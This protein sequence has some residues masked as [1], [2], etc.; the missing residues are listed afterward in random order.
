M[1]QPLQPNA[2]TTE[3]GTWIVAFDRLTGKSHASGRTLTDERN[4]SDPNAKLTQWLRTKSRDEINRTTLAVFKY[5]RLDEIGVE[6]I[7]DETYT[8]AEWLYQPE[9]PSPRYTAEHYLEFQ[10][11]CQAQGYMEPALSASTYRLA[12]SCLL[13]DVD[14]QPYHCY[15]TAEGFITDMPDFSEYQLSFPSASQ[16]SGLELTHPILNLKI[17][18]CQV[19]AQ[20]FSDKRPGCYLADYLFL[21]EWAKAHHCSKPTLWVKQQLIV[22]TPDL[23]I[24]THQAEWRQFLVNRQLE[25]LN[26]I[27]RSSSYQ[28]MLDKCKQA[29]IPS[30]EDQNQRVAS[31]QSRRR[32]FHR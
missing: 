7:P 31:T 16:Y 19:T 11:Y 21:L 30:H 15:N 9:T 23:L 14:T 24:A 3:P 28:L 6:A 8:A 5:W 17:A 22:G 25:D 10:Q 13:D 29:Q 12:Q 26:R 20:T 2:K 1:I 18:C 4:D 32:G 27:E